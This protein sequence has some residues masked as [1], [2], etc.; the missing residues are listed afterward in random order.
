LDAVAEA[1]NGGHS[2]TDT[3]PT[4]APAVAASDVFAAQMAPEQARAM[5][6]SLKSD[7]DFG[8]LLL[9]KIGHGE[10]ASPEVQAAK[11]KWDQLHKVAFPAPPEYSPEQIKDLPLHHDL[12]RQAEMTSTRAMEMAAAG[13]TP[14]QIHQIL[15]VRPVPAAEHE[16]AEQRYQALK[17]DKAFM[18]RWSQ[19][20]RSAVLQMRLAVS[21]RALPVAKSL[22]DIEAWDRAH[23]FTGTR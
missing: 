23:P 9:T 12:R 8:K 2:M 17:R 10:T 7:R 16:M 6:E 11:S 1:T 5:I 13:Y 15:G 19:G 3:A 14:V 4:S 21:A 18:E 20:D 22:A